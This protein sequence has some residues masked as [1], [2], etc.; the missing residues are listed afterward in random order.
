MKRFILAL[1]LCSVLTGAAAA[2]ANGRFPSA[3]HI[4][5]DPMDP[6]H[7][8]VR[9][10]YGLVVSRD[11]GD[12]WHWVCEKAMS[13]NGIWDPPI[14]ILANGIIIAGLPDGLSVS[15]PDACEF[16]RAPA[17]EGQFVADVAVD[18]KNPLRAVVLTSL[19]LGGTF[20]TR[21]FQTTDGGKTFAQVGNV[22]PENLRGLTVDLTSD[23]N[24]LYVSGISTGP[25]PRGVVFRSNDDGLSY[26]S[27]D[28]PSSDQ[29]H[30]PFI[31]AIDPEIPDRVYVRLDGTP[32]RLLVS[33]NGGETWVELFSGD[34]TLL[35]FG[36]APDGKTLVVGGEK[37]GVW[38]SPAPNWAFEKSSSLHPRCFRWTNAGIYACTEQVLDGYS[39]GFS[40]TDGSTFKPLATLSDLCGPVSCAKPVCAADWPLLRDTISAT[41]CAEVSSSSS[42]SSGNGS[43]S[44]NGS[45]GG[46][47]GAGGTGVEPRAVGGG[48]HCCLSENGT[49][50]AAGLGILPLMALL[51]RRRRRREHS[52]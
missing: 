38:R 11:G 23:P 9:S 37:D 15:T 29:D 2:Q 35:G 48:C 42:A 39:I 50:R 5:V 34:G 44:S 20:A 25:L 51:M 7:I 26:Q 8:V 4:E 18:K 19:P 6:L 41:P 17:L 12:T 14:G 46:Q 27:F 43:S 47:G 22:F 21:L 24:I 28:V 52:S 36:L 16:V 40:I 45:S 1:G 31:G 30:A 33:E 32:G 10:T 3:G 49:S 13:F